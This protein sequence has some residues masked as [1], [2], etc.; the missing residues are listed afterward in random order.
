M[1]WTSKIV[2]DKDKTNVGQATAIWNAGQTDE[3]K[4]SRRVTFTVAEK[5]AFVAEAI[6]AKAARATLTTAEAS[7]ESQLTTA[8]NA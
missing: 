8:L 4:Y 3:F 2:I 1:A 6:A 5:N 7:F